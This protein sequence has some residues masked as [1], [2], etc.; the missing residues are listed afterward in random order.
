MIPPSD[1][2]ELVRQCE[3]AEVFNFHGAHQIPKNAV[4][5]PAILQDFAQRAV[6]CEDDESLWV[7]EF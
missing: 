3:N 6:S 2:R 7:D 4:Q 1:T 5:F